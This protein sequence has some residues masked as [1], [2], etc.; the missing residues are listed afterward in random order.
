MTNTIQTLPDEFSVGF[1]EYMK[2]LREEQNLSLNE[3]QTKSDISTTLLEKIESGMYI[4][5]EE[6]LKKLSTPLGTTFANL[7]FQAGHMEDMFLA[8]SAS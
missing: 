1:G 4:P 7:L 3:L 5:T 6:E 8:I 2:Y